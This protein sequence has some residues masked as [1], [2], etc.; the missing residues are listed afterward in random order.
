MKLI[1]ALLVGATIMGVTGTALALRLKPQTM[2]AIG[3]WISELLA[4]AIMGAL[5]AVVVNFVGSLIVPEYW[6]PAVPGSWAMAG[7]GALGGM[8][9]HCFKSIAPSKSQNSS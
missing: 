5:L 6:W 3:R 7:A 2:D 9:T 8:L 1:V 4:S